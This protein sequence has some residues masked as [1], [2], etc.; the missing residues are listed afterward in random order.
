M[1]GT[2][3]VYDIAVVGAGAYGTSVIGHIAL[4]MI[5]KGQRQFHILVLESSPDLGPG[6]PYS[7]RMTIPDHIV[8]HRWRE[9]QDRTEVGVNIGILGC[10]LSAIDTALTLGNKNGSFHSIH[11]D[12]KGSLKF[13]PFEGAEDFKLTMYGT[14]G[15]APSS[16][17]RGCEQ[18][19]RVQANDGFLPLDDFWYLLKREIYDEVPR[20][21]PHLPCDWE[22]LS[23]EEA[24]TEVRRILQATDPVE[25][26]SQELDDARES[27]KN[28]IPLRLQNVFYQSYAIFDEAFNYFSAEDRIRF[29]EFKTELHLLIG[30]FPVQNAEKIL[31]LMKG[32]YLEV[33]K[34][35]TDYEIEE[36]EDGSGIKLTWRPKGG[37][38]REA[39]HD[40]MVDATGQKGAFEK[41]NSPLTTSLRKGKLVKE[42]FGPLFRSTKESLFH[43]NH[44][45]VVTRD[46][47]RYFRPSGAL[48][49]INN[50]SLV[51]A[52]EDP[53]AP[54]YYMGPFTLGQVAFP[55]DMSV[56]TTAAERAV[57]D[58]IERGVLERDVSYR[59]E[60]DPMPMYGWLP[61]AKGDL[62][63]QMERMS[64]ALTARI[65][66][67][68]T[69]EM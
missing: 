66:D 28:G 67:F 13:V 18:D 45:N 17:G 23:L 39:H 30:P 53:C 44:P 54:I 19:F 51:T 29:E 62:N 10:S 36:A 64:K 16:H 6:M 69:K 8:K 24:V 4:H 43:Q 63:G 46:G 11:Q 22:T 7:K 38:T 25:R 59:A 41:D 26:L 32:N 12:G 34:I 49:D 68:M 58:L 48:I 21:R 52:S 3:P 56:V 61:N 42:I 5:P 33:T 57:T 9:L 37:S 65:D 1:T 20:L 55:Q 27:L 31:A 14:E 2:H 35:G 40:V 50:F 60:E 15:N 47:V